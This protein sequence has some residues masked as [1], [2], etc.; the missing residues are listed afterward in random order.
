[1]S[2]EAS[3]RAQ[4]ALTLRERQVAEENLRLLNAALNAARAANAALNALRA[5]EIK[6]QSELSV[7]RSKLKQL[8]YTD[9]ELKSLNNMK[10]SDLLKLPVDQRF[11]LLQKLDTKDL[12]GYDQWKKRNILAYLRGSHIDCLG[13]E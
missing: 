2:S 7:K 11:P 5:K 9:V 4:L 8:G 13:W 6:L 10:I 3:I 1:M 12:V